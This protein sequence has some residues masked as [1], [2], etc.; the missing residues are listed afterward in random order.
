MVRENFQWGLQGK[1]KEELDNSSSRRDVLEE[2]GIELER[3]RDT[4]ESLEREQKYIAQ[5]PPTWNPSY[6]SKD[7]RIAKIKGQIDELTSAQT[8]IDLLHEQAIREDEQEQINARQ[9]RAAR[10]AS[11]RIEQQK[12]N[13][14][15]GRVKR[16]FG[17]E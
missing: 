16:L 6:T 15:W 1:S 7:E 12:R 10:E 9:S 3:R 11:E 8:P 5:E 13:S 2:A 17:G 14:A 4:A